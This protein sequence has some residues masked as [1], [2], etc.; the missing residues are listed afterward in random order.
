M[1]QR[2]CLSC[3]KPVYGRVDKKFCNNTCRNDYNNLQN[4]ATN[5]YIRKVNRILKRNRNILESLTPKDK[6]IKIRAKELAKE[7][8]SFEYFTHQYT[9]KVGK[10]YNFCYEYGY[11][12]L[13]DDYFALVYNKQHKA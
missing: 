7:G 6:S 4:S 2:E 3:G 9:T 1:D 13:D 10:T 8:F 11:L 12:M 5:S